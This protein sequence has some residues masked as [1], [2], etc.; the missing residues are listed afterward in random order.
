MKKLDNYIVELKNIFSDRLKSVFIYGSKAS[1]DSQ[2]L[3]GDIDLMVILDELKGEDLKK[4]AKPSKDWMDKCCIFK[5]PKNPEPIFMGEK[6]WFNSADVY[7]MEYADIKENHKVVYGENLI[8][9]IPVKKEDLR[10][11]CEAQTKNLLMR[12]RS[13]YLLYADNAKELAKSIIP[14]TKTLNAIFKTILRLKDI[15]VSKSPYENLNKVHQ[16]F[17]IDKEF[18]EKLLC[19]KENHCKIKDMPHKEVLETAD[20]T[21]FELEKLLEYIN[22]L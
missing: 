1:F 16:I 3:N 10:F 6:E 15:E 11:E 17:D 18:Y 12:F 19:F 9:D 2:E 13:H 4:I 5:K 20:K 21:V 7:A 22:N 8:C 14:V